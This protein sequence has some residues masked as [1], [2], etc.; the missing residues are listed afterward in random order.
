MVAYCENCGS[1]LGSRREGAKYCSNSCRTLAHRKRHNIPSPLLLKET[2]LEGIEKP[3]TKPYKELDDVFSSLL[4]RK[5]VLRINPDYQAAKAKIDEMKAER[6]RLEKEKLHYI[7]RLTILLNES[8]AL[9][10]ATI[11]AMA[12]GG[13]LYALADK[14]DKVWA[15]LFG[16]LLGGL[17][18]NE[19][20]NRN[21]DV[22]KQAQ[23]IQKIKEKISGLEGAIFLADWQIITKETELAQI[24]KSIPLA[25]PPVKQVE[26]LLPIEVAEAKNEPIQG[27]ITSKK[28]VTANELT[29]KKFETIGFKNEYLDF[30]GDPPDGFHIAVYGLPNHGKSTWALKFA[31]YLSQNHGKVLYVSSEEAHSKTISDKLIRLGAN[32][33]LIGVA[34]YSGDDVRAMKNL[35]IYRFVVLDSADNMNLSVLDVENWKINNP[36]QSL[37]VIHQ[38]TKE[39][40]LR[41]SNEIIHNA[42]AVICIENNQARLVK[43]RYKDF[44]VAYK[45]PA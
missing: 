21:Y 6:E 4:D 15:A 3:Q 35:K 24:K 19:I 34:D 18:G 11:G 1:S 17:A 8:P 32:T 41:G 26:K 36:K 40:V 2:S 7:E 44:Q 23:K 37:I 42:G 9:A 27:N 13:A 5:P 38:T 31:L 33:D 45:I 16:A 29:K 14:K 22:E 28:I 30:L 43:N 39:G 20:G 12:G 25:E 10:S